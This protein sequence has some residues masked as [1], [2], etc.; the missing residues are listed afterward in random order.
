MEIFPSRAERVEL[1]LKDTAEALMQ[2]LSS[3]RSKNSNTLLDWLDLKLN[4]ENDDPPIIDMKY[5]ATYD[6]DF[7]FKIAVDGLH[8]TPKRPGIFYSVIMSLNPPASLYTE[9]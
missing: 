2:A 1:P 3:S 9:S 6:Q 5:F 4:V 7:G 8:N